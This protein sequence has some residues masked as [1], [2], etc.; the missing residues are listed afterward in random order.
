MNTF[1]IVLHFFSCQILSFIHA[2]ILHMNGLNVDADYIPELGFFSR[3][4]GSK[5]HNLY[6]K[7]PCLMRPFQLTLP[8][9]MWAFAITWHPS[10]VN[11]SHFNLL[12][13]NIQP[14]ELKLG[15][16]HLWKVLYKECS[17][18]PD[19]LKNMATTGNSCF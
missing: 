11:F 4:F 10:S 9:A 8:R 13:W 2:F 17:F 5:Y 15:R 12:L 1:F 3:N 18:C 6:I 16:K 7:T 14:N 19:S